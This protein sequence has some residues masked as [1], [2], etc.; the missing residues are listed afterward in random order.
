MVRVGRKLI[1]RGA[2]CFI[3]AEAGINHNGDIEMAKELVRQAARSGADA[4]KFQVFHAESLVI[5]SSPDFEL[6]KRYELPDSAWRDLAVLAEK[7]GIVFLATPFDIDAVNLLEEIGVPAYK[8]AS[9]D[10]TNHELISYVARKWKPIFLSTGGAT[11][12]EISLALECIYGEENDRIVLLHCVSCYPTPEEEVN[13][14]AIKDLWDHFYLPVGL[15]DHTLGIEAALAAVSIGAVAIEK[16]FT[17]DRSLPGP[18]HLHSLTPSEL[19]EMIGRIRKIEKMLGNGRKEPMPCEANFRLRG[20]RGVKAKRDIP[21]GTVI[22]REM[23]S[24]LR[25]RGAIGAEELHNV[26]GRRAKRDIA[27]GEDIRWEDLE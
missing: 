7:E 27:K 26:L 17:L 14:S 9:G 24:V 1:G 16:H 5:E 18:D 6:F 19:A 25:P 20:R 8:I 3:I 15:S 4:V 23:L 10:L 2:P 13:L 12:K 22:S 21:K 11:L